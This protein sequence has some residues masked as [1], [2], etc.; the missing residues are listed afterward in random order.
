[1]CGYETWSLTPR[2]E[3]KLRVFENRIPSGMYRRKCR[4]V[5]GQRVEKIAYQ[6]LN[7]LYSSSNFIRMIKS[8]SMRWERNVAHIEETLYA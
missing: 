7:N 8:E 1:L 6:E 2:E 3:Y 4:E 5:K